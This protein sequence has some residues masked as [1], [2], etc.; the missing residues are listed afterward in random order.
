MLQLIAVTTCKW[1]INPI[2]NKNPVFGHRYTWQYVFLIGPHF[3]TSALVGGEWS[4]S[5]P[6]HFISGETP[7]TH[8]SGYW[9]DPR[10]G[11]N[12]VEKIN[13]WH[14]RPSNSD[15]SAV[16]PV[17][18]RCN[19]CAIPAPR[20]VLKTI[21]NKTSMLIITRNFNITDNNRDHLCGLVIRF[22]GYRSRGP[23]FDSRRCQILW[24]EMGL[25]RGPLSLMSTS[26]EL[27]GRNK[28]GSGLENR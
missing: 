24:E 25:E 1:S 19:D 14:Y 21:K 23:A 13:S 26:E 6:V 15:P 27:L 4:A 9:V 7:G 8:C 16:Q 12:D 22:P 28:S 17:A 10:T 18:S 11:L 2:T 5:R 3:L 20:L